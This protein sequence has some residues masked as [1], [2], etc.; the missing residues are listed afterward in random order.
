MVE[1]RGTLGAGPAD[2]F[3]DKATAN[4]MPHPWRFHGWAAIPWGS[5]DFADTKLRFSGFIDHNWAAF[6]IGVMS[7]A[8]P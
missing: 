7:K 3:S 4:G 2:T 5:G 6:A 1:R 8:A